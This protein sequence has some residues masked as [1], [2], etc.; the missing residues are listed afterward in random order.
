MGTEKNNQV[1]YPDQLPSAGSTRL[2]AIGRRPRWQPSPGEA[3][4]EGEGHMGTSQVSLASL[5]K[6]FSGEKRLLVLGL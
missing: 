1:L 4:A 5:S 2:M 3:P 6:L